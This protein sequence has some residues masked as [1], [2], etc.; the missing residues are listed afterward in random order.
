[1]RLAAA[2]EAAHPNRRLLLLAHVSEEAVQNAF[3]SPGVFALADEA[4]Q[5]PAEYVPLLFRLG[6]DDL[7]HTVVRNLGLGW[8]MVEKLA[9]GDRH[10]L[11]PVGTIGIAR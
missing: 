10:R 4:P 2:V 1:M 11:L 9:V 8:V 7:R 6:T 5:F 3:E